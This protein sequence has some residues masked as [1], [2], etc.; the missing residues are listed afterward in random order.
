VI[1][2]CLNNGAPLP[3]ECNEDWFSTPGQRG[4]KSNGNGLGG[5]IIENNI[6]KAHGGTIKFINKSRWAFHLRLYLPKQ[7]NREE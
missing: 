1:I 2:N 7:F 3:T 6:V 5:S 4:L